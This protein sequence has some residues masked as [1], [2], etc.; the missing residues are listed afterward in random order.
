MKS[1]NKLDVVR[2]KLVLNQ[3]L[4]SEQPLNNVGAVYELMKKE[5]I[6]YDREVFCILNIQ[7]DG[8]CINMNIVSIGG[9]NQAIVEPRKGKVKYPV[10]G[11]KAQPIE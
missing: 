3:E 9:L 8:R 6:D 2:I 10:E 11:Q 1:E 5:L 7:S 4:Y